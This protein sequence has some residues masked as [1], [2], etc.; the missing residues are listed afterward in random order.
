MWKKRHYAYTKENAWHSK[1]ATFHY[2]G[3]LQEFFRS[4]LNEMKQATTTQILNS[5]LLAKV[6]QRQKWKHFAKNKRLLRTESLLIQTVFTEYRQKENLLMW[7]MNRIYAVAERHLIF[8]YICKVVLQNKRWFCA[9]VCLVRDI[10]W[11]SVETTANVVSYVKC[12]VE[13][14]Y[15]A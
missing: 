10:N 1:K 14:D 11:N 5:S 4:G 13:D 2:Q 6:L 7:V 9:F 3:K 12:L 15:Q 8:L